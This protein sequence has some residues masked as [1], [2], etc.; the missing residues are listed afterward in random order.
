MKIREKYI[1]F[2]VFFKKSGD[3]GYGMGWLVGEGEGEGT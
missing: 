3:M 1:Y 2:T